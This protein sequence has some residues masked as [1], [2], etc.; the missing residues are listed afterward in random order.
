M[1]LKQAWVELSS[2]YS[3]DYVNEEALTLVRTKVF[4][5]SSPIR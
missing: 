4:R 3:D 2:K 1:S 5:C